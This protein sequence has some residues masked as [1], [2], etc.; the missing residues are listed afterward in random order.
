MALPF[1]TQTLLTQLLT[2]EGFERLQRRTAQAVRKL[3]GHD[4]LVRFFHDPG[5]PHSWL[6]AQS[7]VRLQD[8]YA[9]TLIGHTVPPPSYVYERDLLEHRR[10]S[11]RE[12]R[13]TAEEFGLDGPERV[14]DDAETRTVAADLVELEGDPAW[15]D[16]AVH[17]GAALFRGTSIPGLE[18]EVP[19]LARNRDL[20]L[21]LGHYAGGMVFSGGAWF[22]GAERIARLEE[23][24]SKAGAGKG[25]AL[26][27]QPLTLAPLASSTVQFYF[28]FRSPFSY[29]SFIR[30]MAMASAHGLDVDPRPVFAPDDQRSEAPLRKRVYI[31]LDANRE[32][33]HH[34]VTFGR[35][36]ETSDAVVERLLSVFYG[37]D[38]HDDRRMQF[39]HVAFHALWARGLDLA[40]PRALAGI[41]TES[42]ISA[43]ELAAMLSDL[44]WKPQAAENGE[45]LHDH[46]YLEVPAFGCG[47]DIF[48]GYD[49]LERLELRAQQRKVLAPGR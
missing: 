41:A 10:H 38:A 36:G 27:R 44:S 30:L 17:L 23:Q 12:A 1:R 5:C 25:H 35:V 9:F 28:S 21:Q 33:R 11:V 2:S 39:L 32:A 43:K 4:H 37:L 20:Q 45:W 29:L 18:R 46:G 34:N 48:W 8:H 15:L 42:G 47:K 16:Y 3:G 14:P 6:L 26:P 7:L 19:E 22:G 13:L 31:L 24:L 49:R 40:Q